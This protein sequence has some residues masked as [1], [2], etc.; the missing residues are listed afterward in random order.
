MAETTEMQKVYCMPSQDNSAMLAEL[1]NAKSQGT[2]AATMSAL[3]ARNNNDWQSNPFIYLIWMMMF[4]NGWGGDAQNTDINAKLNELSAQMSNNQNTNLMMDAI[5]GNHEALH[6][7]A[8]TLGISFAQMQTAFGNIQNAITQVGGQIGMS[9]QQVINSVLLGNK[10]LT[11]ALQSCCCENKQ[12]VQQMGY[13]GQIRDLQNT[14]ALTSRIDQ[15]ANGITQGFS[16][17]SYA[18][19]QHTNDIIQSGNANTQRI[20]DQLNSH[21]TQELSQKYAD[22]K[23]ELSQSAQN[24]YLISQLKTT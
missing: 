17:T 19:Q 16:A 8:N 10:D 1:I 21:W 3:F 23:L 14:S 11:S 20:I 15:L 6:S 13:E 12:L 24:A 22:A 9:S 2:D 5:N 7:I 18:S 4:R